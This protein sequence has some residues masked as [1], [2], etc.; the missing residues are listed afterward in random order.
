M[1]SPSF[2]R[3]GIFPLPLFC[4]LVSPI[5]LPSSS[6]LAL[7]SFPF[8][9]PASSCQGYRVALEICDQ[10]TPQKSLNRLKQNTNAVSTCTST[11]IYVSWVSS[12]SPAYECLRLTSSCMPYYLPSLDMSI[13]MWT[14]L[15]LTVQNDT[16]FTSLL[17]CLTASHAITCHMHR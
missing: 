6:G 11:C 5:P 15:F 2:Q 1:E 14:V 17:L 3:K 12:R 16:S 9:R 8:L 4:L 10:N 7:F 13:Q